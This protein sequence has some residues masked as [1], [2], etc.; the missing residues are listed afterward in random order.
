VHPARRITVNS[1]SDEQVGRVPMAQTVSLRSLDPG[2]HLSPSGPRDG[3]CLCC[4]IDLRSMGFPAFSAGADGL[5]CRTTVA[6]IGFTAVT[7]FTGLTG[8]GS[9]PFTAGAAA[10]GEPVYSAVILFS[11]SVITTTP[12]MA[13]TEKSANSKKPAHHIAVKR[14][15]FIMCSPPPQS[16]IP[17][18]NEFPQSGRA[19]IMT[20]ENVLC[21]D[22]KSNCFIMTNRW[23]Q[24]IAP[25]PSITNVVTCSLWPFSGPG[26]F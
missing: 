26:W 6:G 17:P 20:A 24:Q 21:A 18:L 19:L 3:R 9:L 1:G 4:R 8:V 2:C 25:Y 23:P 5:S 12:A 22:F 14:P 11:V 15:C 10:E 7:G 16:R 13:G